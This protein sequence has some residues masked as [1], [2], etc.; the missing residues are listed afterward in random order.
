[1]TNISIVI[2][3]ISNHWCNSDWINSQRVMPATT[4]IRVSRNRI[5]LILKFLVVVISIM[6]IKSIS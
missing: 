3:I 2:Q 6:R 1:M 4:I 5:I